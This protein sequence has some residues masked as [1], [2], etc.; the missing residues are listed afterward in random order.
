[1]SLEQVKE[2]MRRKLPRELVQSKRASNERAAVYR[3]NHVIDL[4]KKKDMVTTEINSGLTDESGLHLT[5]DSRTHPFVLVDDY[6]T[7]KNSQSN[8]QQEQLKFIDEENDLSKAYEGGGDDDEM[9]S[10]NTV[11]SLLRRPRVGGVGDE[12]LDIIRRT[13]GNEL[14]EFM[15]DKRSGKLNKKYHKVFI[16]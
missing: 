14:C 10:S 8:E 11:I 2:F 16:C 3:S 1:M 5:N 13:Y 6:L 12:N 15:T 9:D 4:P 7:R